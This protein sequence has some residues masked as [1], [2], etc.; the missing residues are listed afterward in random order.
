MERTEASTMPGSLEGKVA[1]VTGGTAGVGLETAVRLAERRAR[2]VITGRSEERARP[3][4]AKLAQ[5][6]PYASFEAVDSMDAGALSSMFDRVAAK[7]EGGIDYV[8]SAG[9]PHDVGPA[10]FAEMS[11]AEIKLA[12]DSRVY[13]R[14]LPVHT[15]I[16]A[17]RERGGS[18]VMLSTDAARHA[19]SGE[20]VMGAA[21]AVVILMTKTLAREFARWKI[22]VNSVAMTI[23]SDTPSWDR[24]FSEESFQSNLFS[25]AVSR[26]PQGRPPSSGEVA[27]VAAF[28]A[29]DA[30]QVTGQ[31]IS[32]NGG[33]S[34]G[35]W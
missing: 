10:P 12:F 1:V 32:V 18:V 20:S 27:D 25:K 7:N 16:P 9:T 21:G 30:G 15:A 8:I 29:A 4:L 28:L 34:Y 6:T 26:F 17:L 3:A 19:T 24:I 5:F 31:T 11:A 2:V 14:I 22:R 35:G 33:L 13:P 23:T